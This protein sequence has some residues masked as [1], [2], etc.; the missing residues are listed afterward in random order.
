MG[1]EPFFASSRKTKVVPFVPAISTRPRV[2][3]AAGASGSEIELVNIAGTDNA[4]NTLQLSIGEALTLASNMGTGAFVDNGASADTISRTSGS[5]LDDGWRVGDRLFPSGA[6]TLANDFEVIL[7]AV[8]ATLLTLA[9]GG[10]TVDTVENLPSTAIL[11]RVARL[12]SIPVAANSGVS[13]NA[14]V[15]GLSPTQIPGFAVSPDDLLRLGPNHALIG[16]L[17][18]AVGSGEIIDVTSSGGDY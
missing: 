9:T 4:A 5:F 1:S 8:T 3:W 12:G 11:Y 13:G 18:T 7:T 16:A 2:L 14:A 6:T 10:G 15:D 17:A